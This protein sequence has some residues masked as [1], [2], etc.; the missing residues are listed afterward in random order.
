MIS[1]SQLG[2]EE[3]DSANAIKLMKGPQIHHYWDGGQ[4]VGAVVRH[5]VPGL[6]IPAWDLWMAYRPGT[7][8]GNEAPEPDWWEHQLSALS[9]DLAGRRLDARRFVR[10]AQG[11]ASQ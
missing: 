11:L 3:K 4:R 10:K 9:R 8:W 7:I 5:F 2:A 6:E 1:S